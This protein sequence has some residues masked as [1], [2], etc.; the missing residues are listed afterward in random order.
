LNLSY[1]VQLFREW[2]SAVNIPT[3]SIKS[4]VSAPVAEVLSVGTTWPMPNPRPKVTTIAAR[5]SSGA[6]HGEQACLRQVNS[7]SVWQRQ[8]QFIA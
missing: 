5:A 6:R 3:K 1:Q 4:T 8:E 7:R 2:M